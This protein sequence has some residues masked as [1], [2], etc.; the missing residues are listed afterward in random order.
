[1]PTITIEIWSSL[2]HLF[3]LKKRR[4]HFMDMEIDAGTTLAGV[5]EKIAE[6]YPRFAKVMY[7]PDSGKPSGA[8]SVV[9]NERLPELLDGY[10]TK[11]DEGDRIVLVQ[12]YSG[13]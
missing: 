11:L 6:G 5:L 9:V 3:E 4:R 12:A 2:S 7:K 1:M 8:I 13:G 10:E